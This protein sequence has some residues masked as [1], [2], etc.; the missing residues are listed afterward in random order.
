M[1]IARR[2]VLPIANVAIGA[3]LGLLALKAIT[4]Y[5]S[6]EAYG[7]LEGAIAV[8]GIVYLFAD[9]SMSEAHIKRVSEGVSVGDCFATFAVF[10]IASSILFVLASAGALF[11]YTVVLGRTLEDISTWAILFAM[12]YYVGKSAMS[13][14]QSTFDAQLEQ[15][16][17]QLVSFVETLVR[18]VLTV[19]VAF[20]FAAL[21][22][23]SG[24][25]VGRIAGDSPF[26]RF[27]ATEPAAALAAAWAIAAIVATFVS[28]YYLVK[29]RVRGRFRWDILRSYFAFAL[30]LFLP[31]ALTII[32][33]FIDRTVLTFFGTDVDT[34][35][36]SA[37]RR[38]VTVLEG[39]SMAV[40]LLL[41]PALS[42]MLAR[43]E[44]ENAER[45]MD[46]S[47]RYLSILMMPIAAFLLVFPEPIILIGLGAAYL[48]SATTLAV[49]AIA[50]MFITLQ[51]P[52]V[53][54]LLGEGRSGMAAR[55]GFVASIANIV[56]VFWL[57]P[58]DI[59]SLGLDLPGLK[60]LGAAISLAVSSALGYVLFLVAT[61]R[62][63]RYWPRVAFW[64]HVVASAVM[65]GVLWAIDTFTPLHP[66]RWF[67][68]PIF[69]ALGMLVYAAALVA[70][71]E[72]T[73][74]DVHMLRD[75][76]H[77]GEMGRYLRK[78]LLD[79]EE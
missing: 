58:D 70:V 31:Q 51:R 15:A 23:R 57:V 61:K 9:L 50:T 4:V 27:I 38:I 22:N 49:L 21:V 53:H 14:G 43:G 18:V 28:F 47:L 33:V 16:R 7:E 37:P 26:A 8:L 60:A 17:S 72:L 69:I 75:T 30:P 34:A 54:L 63:S 64:K 36:F 45:T 44:R 39:V 1:T 68:L 73:R 76:L 13:I 77:P 66:G 29:S 25:L 56:L 2:S 74:A 65:V 55:I 20:A 48:S 3:L 40:G 5:M 62:V 11:V 79:H 19:A 6:K 35:D 67:T 12:L 46:K 41:F 32:A 78:E 10:R 59:K 24:P 71:R 52:H 42:A